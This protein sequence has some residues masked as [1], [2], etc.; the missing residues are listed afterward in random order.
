MLDT[1]VKPHIVTHLESKISRLE[2]LLSAAP[3]TIYARSPFNPFSITFVSNSV[4]ELSGY[5]AED[6]LES[7][8]L[9]LENIHPEDKE[10]AINNLHRVNLN[11][12]SESPTRF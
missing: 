11:K 1:Y 3:L 6:F 4:R 10:N 5:D 7:P 12:R 9:W 8:T 2:H